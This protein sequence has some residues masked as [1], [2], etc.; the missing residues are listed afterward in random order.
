MIYVAWSAVDLGRVHHNGSSA[1][2]HCGVEGGKHIFPQIIFRNQGRR[3]IASSQRETVAHI[4]FQAGGHM[5]RRTWVTP[6]KAT[7]ERH[8]HHFC[9]IWIFTKGF[10]EPRPEW[11]TT[12]VEHW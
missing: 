3:A 11:L 4:V 10:V 9:Q 7:D 1:G 6:F 5:I 2:L 12:N 8:A